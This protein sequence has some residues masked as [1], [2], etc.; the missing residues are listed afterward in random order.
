MGGGI[1]NEESTLANNIVRT[2]PDMSQSVT[3]FHVSLL[4]SD[5]RRS[6]RSSVLVAR[7]YRRH[8]KPVDQRGE[9]EILS[10]GELSRR[11]RCMCWQTHDIHIKKKEFGSFLG[12]AEGS[13]SQLC[14][15]HGT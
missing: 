10:D 6:L 9:G 12:F 5:Y 11:S 7:V 14:L 3:M 8:S 1:K 13:C 2:S 4:E 15:S